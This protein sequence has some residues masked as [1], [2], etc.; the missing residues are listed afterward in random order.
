VTATGNIVGA[1]I[2]ISAS[3]S[4][5]GV[6]VE[7]IV[8]QPTTVAFDSVSMANVG[9]LGFFVL[10]GYSYKFEAYMPVL[11]AGSTTTGFSTYFDAGICYYTV[12][13][14]PAQTTAFSA[15]TSNVSGTAAAT[16]SMTGTDPRAV[17]ITGTI[18]SAG[19]ANVAIQA[20]TSAANINIQSGAFL[21]YTRLS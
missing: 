16:Q 15:S 3:S 17:R 12:E 11:P 13:A 18:Y 8:W 5:T 4:G 21:T 1:N 10:G 20:Q 2:S 7:N 19:N 14:Q 9:T 6:G